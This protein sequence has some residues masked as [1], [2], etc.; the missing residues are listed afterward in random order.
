M[1]DKQQAC[2]PY[3][4][5]ADELIVPAACDEK[6]RWWDGGMPV[7]DIL[8]ELKVSR[9]VWDKYSPDPYP[10]DLAR[11]NYPLLVENDTGAVS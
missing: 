11:E 10:E 5:D 4:N 9:T 1:N 3:I 8:K 6:Y 2:A 7:A